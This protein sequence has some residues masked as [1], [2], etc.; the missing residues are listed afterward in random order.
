MDELIS[1]EEALQ[2]ALIIIGE[3]E[4]VQRIKAKRELIKSQ[5]LSVV[6]PNDPQEPSEMAE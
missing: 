6:E 4:V 2:E 1:T 5:G 3:R